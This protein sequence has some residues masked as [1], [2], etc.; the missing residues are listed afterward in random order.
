[1]LPRLKL[2]DRITWTVLLWIFFN[3]FWLRFLEMHI[4]QWV[5]AAIATVLGIAY[6]VYGPDP[7]EAIDNDEE[8]EG[9]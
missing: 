1:M 9:E 2:S 3:L 5:G 6:I 8:V 4:P 7:E